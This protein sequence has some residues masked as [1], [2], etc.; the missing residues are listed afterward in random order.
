MLAVSRAGL[1]CE[2]R[3]RLIQVGRFDTHILTVLLAGFVHNFWD[4][5]YDRSKIDPLSKV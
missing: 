5:V 3:G 4:R 1:T 2:V